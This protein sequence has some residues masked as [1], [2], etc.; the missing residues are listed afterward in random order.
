MEIRRATLDELKLKP[1]PEEAIAVLD[2]MLGELR[3]GKR[4]HP[5]LSDEKLLSRAAAA[6]SGEA[7]VLLGDLI[8]ASDNVRALQF[9]QRA[10]SMRH[11]SG[12][13]AMADRLWNGAG[14]EKAPDDALRLYQSA[15]E[16][17]DVRALETLA[18][19]QLNG[20]VR[21][22]ESSARELLE[23]AAEAG[24][25]ASAASLGVLYLNGFGVGKDPRRAAGY[26]EKA[27][28]G[29][30]L[31]GMLYFARCLNAGIGVTRNT[32]AS[33][34]WFRKAAK[35]GNEQAVAWCQRNGEE[36]GSF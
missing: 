28:L 18:H 2:T 26:F 4:D 11:A 22:G 13:M 5:W 14:V 15:A 31:N 33:R 10:A 21:A 32:K 20:E 36:F 16:A 29:G 12:M 1:N 7:L 27:A 8:E 17:G 34:R 19:L 9:Y 6:G 25:S 3:D 30:D 35:A 24:S 23:R